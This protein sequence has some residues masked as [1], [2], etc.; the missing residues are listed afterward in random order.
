M[1]LPGSHAQALQLFISRSIVGIGLVPQCLLLLWLSL[2][3]LL[4]S[5]PPA[6]VNN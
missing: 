3:H 1:P 4:A 2:S 5:S 6:V